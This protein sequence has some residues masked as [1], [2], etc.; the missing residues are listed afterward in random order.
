MVPTAQA[1]SQEVRSCRGGSIFGKTLEP[2]AKSQENTEPRD[3]AWARS[4]SLLSGC[5]GCEWVSACFY[6]VPDIFRFNFEVVVWSPRRGSPVVGPRLLSVQAEGTELSRAPE[7]RAA[8]PLRALRTS[9]GRL[10]RAGSSAGNAFDIIRADSRPLAGRTLLVGMRALVTARSGSDARGAPSLPWVWCPL[11]CR[12]A[13]TVL[14]ASPRGG[15]DGRLWGTRDVG[16]DASPS[17]HEDGAEVLA[18]G[19]RGRGPL[20][21]GWRGSHVTAVWELCLT[22]PMSL[23][24]SSLCPPLSSSCL[25]LS[26]ASSQ[27]F[28]HRDG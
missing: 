18:E 7:L 13:L 2:D 22:A 8:H 9:R 6:L 14:P 5:R 25:R 16:S 12:R 27:L 21:D 26:R 4:A 19:R 28:G 10:A 20:V 24:N 15:W 17:A 1:G 11:C 3:T 23:G